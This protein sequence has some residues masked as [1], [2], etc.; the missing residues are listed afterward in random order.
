MF[1]IHISIVLLTFCDHLGILSF[2]FGV[3]AIVSRIFSSTVSSKQLYMCVS[4]FVMGG[5]VG[6]P[7]IMT[8]IEAS[9]SH[10]LL[11]L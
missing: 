10:H 1:F 3:S 8:A 7:G 5:S 6:A 11:F 9:S 2:V 4:L